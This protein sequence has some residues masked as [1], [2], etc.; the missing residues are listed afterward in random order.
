MPYRDRFSRAGALLVLVMIG[1]HPGR[2]RAGLGTTALP[3]F[4]D[5]KPSVQV[6]AAPGVVKRGRLQTEFLCSVTAA[7]PVDVGVEVF[8]ADGTRLND[9]QAGAGALLGV[10][11]GQTV[12]FGTS[13]TAAYLESAALSLPDVSQGSARVVASSSGVGCNVMMLDDAVTPPLS[14]AT[15]SGGVQLATGAMLPTALPTFADGQP[16][17]ASA[18]IPGIVKRPPLNTEFFCTSMAATPIDVGVEIFGPEGTLHNSISAGNGAVLNVAA[19]AT[20]TFGTSGTA[21]FLESAVITTA[22]VSQG[23]ARIVSTSEQITCTALVLDSTMTP[24]A[25]MSNLVGWSAN[26]A[27]PTVTATAT[28]PLGTPV[29]STTPSATPTSTPT[30][31]GTVTP[32]TTATGTPTQAATPSSRPSPSRTPIASP[33]HTAAATVTSSSTTALTATPTNTATQT[34][35]FT[36]ANTATATSRSTPTATS[37]VTA[38]PTDSATQTGTPTGTNTATATPSPSVTFTVPPT[39]AP[40]TAPTIRNAPSATVTPLPTGTATLTASPT[41]SIIPSPLP[42]ATATASGT[43]PPQP[44]LTSLPTPTA[45]TPPPVTTQ[46]SATVTP[47]PNGTAIATATD[48]L[49]ASPTLVPT[50]TPSAAASVVLCVGDRNHNGTVTIDELVF[51]I[52]IVVGNVAPEAGS[53]FDANHDGSVTVD[54]LLAAA[55]AALNGCTMGLRA[56]ISSNDILTQQ[57]RAD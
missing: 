53:A 9:V 28:V 22:A 30:F 47:S 16:A 37:A 46:G 34:R 6:L 51:G 33:T 12:T 42:T 41:S 20:V 3:Q 25:S 4:A 18:V 52:N 11:S 32:S 57:H 39:A 54:E 26:S 48:T 49:V 7:T 21:G 50:A 55:K 10:A 15:L 8:A 14:L 56:S 19:G 36:G 40:S 1:Q 29:P 44:S 31:T 2:A 43:A 45:T 13:G 17:T 27:A 38:A 23:V 5:G 24:P 35:T